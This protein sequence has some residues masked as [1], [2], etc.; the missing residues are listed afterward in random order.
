[1]M[2]NGIGESIIVSAV[3]LSSWFLRKNKWMFTSPPQEESS[4]KL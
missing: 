3:L 4:L 1:M 2:G